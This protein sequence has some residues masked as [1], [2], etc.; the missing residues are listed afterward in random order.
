M[1]DLEAGVHLQ[2]VGLAVGDQELDRAGAGV[3]HS[4]GG[5]YGQGVQ[6]P[7]ELLGESGCRGLLDHLLVAA[8]EGAVPGAQGPDRAVRVGEDLHL[9]VPAAL[10]IRLDEHLAVPEGA[11]GFGAGAL[12][13]GVQL[14][15]SAHDTHAAPPAARGRLHEYGQVGLGGPGQGR[16][17]H[18]LLGARLGRHRLD[19]LR[20]RADPDQ[21]RVEDGTG[22][23][24]V[25]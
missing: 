25:L 10:H 1:F 2:E 12:Q 9:D 16:D 19:R 4:A 15:E 22:E 5:A 8:L 21:A 11:R 14:V 3:V 17:P 7:G 23:V 24:G 20:G 18:Q 6:F 13:G